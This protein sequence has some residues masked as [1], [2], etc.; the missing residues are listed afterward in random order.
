ME[1]GAYLRRRCAQFSDRPDGA[2]PGGAGRQRHVPLPGP[3]PLRQRRVHRCAAAAA[4][5]ALVEDVRPG[6]R[7]G[8]L[9]AVFRGACRSRVVR[10]RRHAGAGNRCNHRRIVAA[11]RTVRAAAVHR[12]PCRGPGDRNDRAVDRRSITLA[13]SCLPAGRVRAARP[14][15]RGQVDAAA[16]AGRRC[17]G[18]QRRRVD[19]RPSAACGTGGG[20]AAPGV[21]AGRVARLS[22]HHGPRTA[23]VRG[24]RQA[25]H[26]LRAG[27]RHRG[28]LRPGPAPGHAVRR[29]V[30]GYPEKADA[31]RC[32]DRRAGRAAAR[33]TVERARCGRQCGAGRPAAGKE[34]GGRGRSRMQ[35]HARLVGQLHQ[36]EQHVGQL[37]ADAGARGVIE[38]GGGAGGQPLEVFHQFGHLHRQRHGQVLGRVERLP[39]ARAGE[40]AGE[41]AQVGQAV[42]RHHSLKDIHHAPHRHRSCRPYL[43][44]PDRRL[45]RHRRARGWQRQN[46][47]RLQQRC[48]AG[49]WQRGGRTARRRH[50]G[51]RHRHQ[52]P[53]ARDRARGRGAIGQGGRRQQPAAAAVHRRQR[54]RAAH[55]RRRQH[56]FHEPAAGD[57]HHA[58]PAQ[59]G[60]QRL[61]AARRHG[62]ERRRPRAEPERFAQRGR[63]RARRPLHGATQWFGRTGRDGPA[64]RRH[65]GGIERLRAPAPGPA[66][67]RNADARLA[68]FRRRQRQRQRGPLAGAPE[69]LGQRGPGPAHQ[70]RGRTDHQRLRQHHGVR[71]RRAGGRQQRLRQHYLGGADGADA[72]HRLV[73]GFRLAV[74][75][76]RSH[77]LGHGV[78]GVGGV[79]ADV[80]HAIEIDVHPVRVQVLGVHLA[81]ALGVE[82]QVFHLAGGG[83]LAGA[84]VAQV[85]AVAGHAGDRGLPRAFHLHPAQRR[86]RDGHARIALA[87]LLAALDVDLQFVVHHLGGQRAHERVVAADLDRLRP[88]RLDG[89]GKRA[90]GVD[91]DE[92]RHRAHGFGGGHGH[93]GQGQGGSHD[94]GE[95]KAAHG[96]PFRITVFD[97]IDFT[98]ARPRRRQICARW[99]KKSTSLH[100]VRHSFRDFRPT[101]R[102]TRRSARTLA[103]RH[104]V[105]RR[106]RQLHGDVRLL[107]VRLL[108]QRHCR[109]LLPG[110]RRRGVADDDLHDLWRRLFDAAP[111]RHHPRRLCRPRGPPQG[112]DR[113]A[114]ADG[115][116]HAADRLRARLRH[117]RL[118]GAAAGTDRAPAAGL[119]GRRG[120]GRRVRVPGRN[121]HPGPQGVLCEL[122]VGQPAG[123]HRGGCRAGLRP[124]P[125]DGAR[126]SDRVGL[127]PA[128]L[129]RLHDRARAVRDPPLAAGDRGVQGAQAPPGIERDFPLDGRQLAPGHRGHDAGVD[130]HR[131]VLPDHRV[132][133]HVRQV[134]AA[135][136]DQ[137]GAAGDAVRGRLQLRLAARDGQPVGPHRPP[138]LADRL[139]RAGDPDGLAGAALAGAGAQ[140]YAH[141]G[142]GAM[143]VVPVRQ[144]QRRHGGG[145]H[146]SD[147]G[148][149]A[150]GGLLAGLQPGHCPLRRLYAGR[151]HG[152]DRG[153]R[154]QERAGLVAHVCRRVRAAGHADA[155]I[156]VD[157]LDQQ[158]AAIGLDQARRQRRARGF[159]R[160]RR[161]LGRVELLHRVQVVHQQADG[162]CAHPHQH[163]LAVVRDVA[164]AA[165][166][167]QR[168]VEHPHEMVAPTGQRRIE[169]AEARRM[170]ACRPLHPGK[171]HR[172]LDG[173]SL[174][175]HQR[176][177]RIK[178][179]VIGT[180]VG[181]ALHPH[182]LRACRRQCSGVAHRAEGLQQDRQHR[183]LH[184]GVAAKLA[185]A[186]G[187]GA[188]GNHVLAAVLHDQ[189]AAAP[190]AVGRR[191]QGGGQRQYIAGG[192]LR[193]G[194]GQHAAVGRDE[195]RVHVAARGHA[196]VQHVHQLGPGVEH[197]A[198]AAHHGR[199]L[200]GMADRRMVDKSGR[201][202]VQGG[203]RKRFGIVIEV[204]AQ[205]AH[206]AERLGV[207]LPAQR[208]LVARG[209][210]D[211]PAAVVHEQARVHR[212]Q[213]V[214]VR[215]HG[216]HGGRFIAR[217]LGEAAPQL[218]GERP[219]AAVV[220]A[221]VQ[222]AVQHI[223]QQLRRQ[224]RFAD[225][226]GQH[227][228]IQILDRARK[229]RVAAFAGLG[230]LVE[231]GIELVHPG[232]GRVVVGGAGDLAVPDD[233]LDGAGGARDRA[234]QLV[235]RR[236]ECL[237]VRQQTLDQVLGHAAQRVGPVLAERQVQR[238]HQLRLPARGAGIALVA[239]GAEGAHQV[240]ASAEHQRARGAVRVDRHL[241][242]GR[243][244]QRIG[245]ADHAV[246]GVEQQ[247]VGALRR[248]AVRR[249]D[250]VHLLFEIE[251]QAQHPG[252]L[253]RARMA[254]AVR[255]HERARFAGPQVGGAEGFE[256]AVGGQRLRQQRVAAPGHRRGH[257]GLH[258]YPAFQVEQQDFVVHGV[259]VAVGGEPLARGVEVVIV[260]GHEAAQ[261][262]IGGQKAHVGRALEQV[263]HQ[264]V[265][266]IARLRAQVGQHVAHF[267]LHQI[268]DQRL[269]Q[270]RKSGARGHHGGQQQARLL[271]AVH[272]GGRLDKL[273]HLIEFAQRQLAARDVGNF[274]ESGARCNMPP[275][276]TPDRWRGVAFSAVRAVRLL[277]AQAFLHEGLAVVAFLAGRIGITFFHFVLLGELGSGHLGRCRAQALLHER[278]ALVAFFAGGFGIAGFHLALL[279][280]RFGGN[281]RPA[282]RQHRA[283]YAYG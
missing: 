87:R 97:K 31:G 174:E 237:R 157:L 257:V 249:E 65:R 125:A 33:R 114:G 233:A 86:Q 43:D 234:H 188:R 194:A 272:L 141:A 178:N 261:V 59:A 57:G 198:D 227:G 221:F 170:A 28:T 64:E 8:V 253:A 21:R 173:A 145:A 204:A 107:P 47:F 228:L 163:H 133:A 143:V 68:R 122:A 140:F 205:R 222:V 130:D 44:Y 254:H 34:R 161:H 189:R 99:Q 203:R 128:V 264:D 73:D 32:L 53:D 39:V 155:A 75:R 13:A 100:H 98:E 58:A 280:G 179:R 177:P 66:A 201:A 5:A 275:R 151:G 213:A 45:R 70:S 191:Q 60:R 271:R 40:L 209:G 252:R 11:V 92:R 95:Q 6:G 190:G 124:E 120:T 150:H 154:R 269:L 186:A 127:A 10:G 9:P 251:A 165:G 211:A 111:G 52:R 35:V 208:R 166:G 108:R 77:A 24:A 138:S 85:Q 67:G 224:L 103:R 277:G 30:A 159:Q 219:P 180:A 244:P 136:D 61:R 270:V 54:R 69:R 202:V 134:G 181:Q 147:A 195:V 192:V 248:I 149:S 250:G 63:G 36:V 144:L 265:D 62:A 105:P 2:R 109:R 42:W 56:A 48:G 93:G 146:R 20:Q 207:E 76:E 153:H 19:R 29:H 256:I 89:H 185:V 131:V 78:D 162:G 88:A 152:P 80:A 164:G 246:V 235:Q 168:Q 1:P 55:P 279:G 72:R 14:Q 245:A 41:G 175:R 276:A 172:L 113:H 263:A 23:G 215:Q 278:L 18:R 83:E 193:I 94:G 167:Q 258:Q 46:A 260:A 187:A 26:G 156:E 104:R 51:G 158:I 160:R 102:P 226:S 268:G 196:A 27:A 231:D 199:L 148:G 282:Q 239:V 116:R 259:L 49:Q 12:T 212:V 16:R 118:P 139:H 106:Q 236:A 220:G 266:R 232:A 183:L 17:A 50:G 262:G 182:R 200:V 210:H 81:H 123:G 115:G 4:G 241:H 217:R 91:G 82:P 112:P 197:D 90:L 7:G 223:D 240:F 242:A 225:A 216:A 129:C 243:Y 255:V 3:D 15:R 214:D 142:S 121:G 132:H 25:L 135:P 171:R 84:Q 229:Q 137:R 267:F 117:H 176:A 247:H 96:I 273:P 274:P 22:V 74:I 38:F 281:N 206:A 283:G 79:H 37:V 230:D 110:R 101:R 169:H 184:A 238:H 119:F 71:Q 218:G 126:A